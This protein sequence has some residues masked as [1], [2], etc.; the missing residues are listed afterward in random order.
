ML[1]NIVS[2][3]VLSIIVKDNSVYGLIREENDIVLT[4]FNLNLEIADRMAIFRGSRGFILWAERDSVLVG[5][6][7]KLFLVKNGIQ[8]TVLRASNVGN[9]FWHAVEAKGVVF[10][11]EYGV[12][13]TGIYASSD[14][15]NWR[16]LIT[17]IDLDKSSRHFHFIG[18]DPYRDWLI[19]TLGDGCLTRVVYSEDLG[20]NWKVLYRGSWQFVPMVALKN[21]IVFG[22]DSGIVRGG[23]GIYHAIHRVWKFIFLKWLGKNIRYVQMCD[24]KYLNDGIW[25]AALGQPQAIV[26]SRDLENWRPLYIEGFINR[27]NHHMSIREG[28]A[29]IVSNTGKRLVLFEK[30]RISQVLDKEPVIVKYKAYL[31]RLRGFIF[32]LKRL[33]N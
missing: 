31:D 19:A 11:H 29:F 26:I 2:L 16:K 4:V 14:L 9:I 21:R 28:D 22:M 12:S 32:K 18:Y 33:R 5:I 30:N 25:I 1:R 10:V 17:N 24:L 20:E 15:R 13:P 23:I 6:D 7:N 8:K 3:N 27:F